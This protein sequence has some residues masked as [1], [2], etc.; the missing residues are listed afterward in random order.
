M[1]GSPNGKVSSNPECY[2]SAFPLHAYIHFVW[3]ATRVDKADLFFECPSLQPL[4]FKRKKLPN[5]QKPLKYVSEIQ[6]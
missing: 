1:T 3:A 6:E 5:T 4:V 2:F